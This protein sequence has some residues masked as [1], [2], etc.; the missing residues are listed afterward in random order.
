MK[1]TGMKLK[2][3]DVKE[4]AAE[5]SGQQEAW[6]KKVVEAKARLRAAASAA[7]P[8]PPSP[9]TYS[10]K[11]SGLVRT[12]GRGKEEPRHPYLHVLLNIKIGQLHRRRITAQQAQKELSHLVSMSETLGLRL[13]SPGDGLSLFH[14]QV[15]PRRKAL[16]RLNTEGEEPASLSLRTKMACELLLTRQGED[17]LAEALDEGEENKMYFEE[18]RRQM[19]DKYFQ[20]SSSSSSSSSS[21]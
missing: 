13:L 16:L 11:V 1:K 20:A 15:K 9:A 18:G 3:E 14:E 10:G 7:S 12:R 8:P 4:E 17:Y 6:N 2:K 21:P 19:E 5:V